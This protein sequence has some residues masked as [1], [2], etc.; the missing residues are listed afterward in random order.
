MGQWLTGELKP[1]D[2]KMADPQPKE[3][4]KSSRT[5]DSTRPST[6]PRT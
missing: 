1:E 3:R 2:A 5:N 6:P 4:R